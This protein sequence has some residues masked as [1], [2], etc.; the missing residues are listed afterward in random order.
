MK[1]FTKMMVA[2]LVCVAVALPLSGCL[3]NTREDDGGRD[4]VGRAIVLIVP[5]QVELAQVVNAGGG[6]QDPGPLTLT[7]T[8]TGYTA[9]P[10]I[11]VGTTIDMEFSIREEYVG[12]YQIDNVTVNGQQPHDLRAEWARFQIPEGTGTVTVEFLVGEFIEMRTVNINVPTDVTYNVVPARVNGQSVVG[13]EIEIT[14][15]DVPAGHTVQSNVGTVDGNVVTVVVPAGFGAF[16]IN[17]TTGIA[18]DAPSISAVGNFIVWEHIEGATGYQVRVN[19]VLQSASQWV[20]AVYGE[21]R[22]VP[23]SNFFIFAAGTNNVVVTATGPAGSVN[24]VGNTLPIVVSLTTTPV[25][26]LVAQGDG[27]STLSW[28]AI[29]GATFEIFVGGIQTQHS[30]MTTTQNTINTGDIPGTFAQGNNQIR[31]RVLDRI[32]G[33]NIHRM[34]GHSTTVTHIQRTVINAPGNLAFTAG[35]LNWTFPTNATA[36]QNNGFVVTVTPAGGAPTTHT[37]GRVDVFMVPGLALDTVF[38]VTVVATT[39]NVNFMNSAPATLTF[40]TPVVPFTLAAPVLTLPTDPWG[41]P[42]TFAPIA[43]ATSYRIIVSRNGGQNEQTFDRVPGDSG[44]NQFLF[45]GTHHYTGLLVI[46]INNLLVSYA[47]MT[48]AS[49]F[50]TITIRIQALGTGLFANSAIGNGL[51]RQPGGGSSFN[52]NTWVVRP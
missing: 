18:L 3:F 8:A 38:T 7:E 20:P 26:T 19:N 49:H 42:I 6:W 40:T 48:G 31:I 4:R 12:Q 25:V 13:E 37:L 14:L 15:T 24:G 28:A 27:T 43:G 30:R 2:V 1:K 34:S 23:L 32:D 46:S 22:R 5:H 35:V 21:Y 50:D 52:D 39:T 47:T 10:E 29:P 44:F 17:I 36:A 33:T 11:Y 51:E 41:D 45:V 16:N 9:A